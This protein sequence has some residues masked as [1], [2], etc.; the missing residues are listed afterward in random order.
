MFLAREAGPELV[1]TINGHTAVA[2]NDQIEAGIERAVSRAIERMVSAQQQQTEAMRR[3]ASKE[4]VARAEPSA[5]WG[6][7]Q[8]QSARLYARTTGG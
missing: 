1:G 4:F 8:S 6:R 5:A 7:M 3:L 2:N